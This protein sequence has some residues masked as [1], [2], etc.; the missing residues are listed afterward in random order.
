MTRPTFAV[1]GASN[2]VRGFPS[3]VNTARRLWGE[4]LDL[5]IAKGHGRSYGIPSRIFG[6]GLP[7][8][9]ESGFFQAL[10]AAPRRSLHALVTD[11]GNDLPY[12][13]PVE[14]ISAWVAECF[15]RL[16]ETGARIA[17]LPLPLEN[18]RALP[19]WK[20]KVLLRA[21]YPSC[22]TAQRD[23]LDRAEALN[24]SIC[25]A[26]GQRNLQILEH[27]PRW[28]GFDPI[29]IRRGHIRPAW[30]ELLRKI[31][32]NAHADTSAKAGTIPKRWLR[33]L[34]PHRYQSFRREF[35][36]SQPQGRWHDG[37]CVHLY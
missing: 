34:R 10:A 23:M 16:S 6:Q 25:S 31:V 36:L 22:R 12:G 8:I 21:L 13:V 18:L 7:G 24:A 33:R 19:S 27:D 17:V 2:V 20:Y 28:Y 14:Q 9:R 5:F 4:P 26:A 11:I 29:H 1:L 32:E 30:N 35:R 15:D 37:T 3:L